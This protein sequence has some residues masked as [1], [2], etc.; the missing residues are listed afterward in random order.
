MSVSQQDV[1]ITC[2]LSSTR[3]VV[4]MEQDADDQQPLD[5]ADLDPVDNFASSYYV[6]VSAGASVHV[7]LQGRPINLPS[8]DNP[9]FLSVGLNDI[10]AASNTDEFKSGPIFSPTRPFLSTCNGRTP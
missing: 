10:R 6:L 3:G 2:S 1:D 8:D 9:Y 5:I 7:F 4:F